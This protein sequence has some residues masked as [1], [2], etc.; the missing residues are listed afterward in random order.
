MEFLAGYSVTQFLKFSGE[1]D[2]FFVHK[3]WYSLEIGEE[4][5]FMNFYA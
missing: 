2:S 1:N 5:T 4:G 3:L